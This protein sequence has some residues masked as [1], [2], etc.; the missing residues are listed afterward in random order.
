MTEFN[1]QYLS[2]YDKAYQIIL[3]QVMSPLKV[4]KSFGV[5]AVKRDIAKHNS[6]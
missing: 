4:T 5:F 6:R 2:P 1:S 3:G